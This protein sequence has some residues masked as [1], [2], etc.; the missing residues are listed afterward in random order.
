MLS[1]VC[2]FVQMK[3]LHKNQS[4]FLDSEKK[5]ISIQ[6]LFKYL[7]VMEYKAKSFSQYFSFNYLPHKLRSEKKISYLQ[8]ASLVSDRDAIRIVQDLDR[9]SFLFLLSSSPKSSATTHH[10]A[11]QW[12]PGSAVEGVGV[13]H[14]GISGRVLDR[15]CPDH[16][17]FGDEGASLPP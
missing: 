11:G 17:V 16:T 4:N 7:S 2:L 10:D 5:I 8:A 3:F 14:T 13:P 1:F 12:G 9:S 15:I 6:Q